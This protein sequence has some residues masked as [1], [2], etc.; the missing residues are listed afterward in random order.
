MSGS[1]HPIKWDDSQLRVINA[2]SKDRVVVGAGPG[3]GKTAV[4]CAR[5]S[6]LIDR[7]SLEP[8]HIWLISFTRTAIREIHARIAAR[9]QNSSA[10]DAVRIA[11]L[12]S[13]AWAIHSGFH[14]EAQILGSYEDNIEKALD[15]IRGEEHV[16]EY[17]E[18]IEHLIIDE[19]QDIVGI[20]SDLLLAII[21][22]LLPTCGVTVF[23]DEAQAIY[24]FADD[25]EVRPGEAR[26]SSLLEKIRLQSDSEFQERELTT[27]HRTSSPQLLQIFSDTRRKV[28]AIANG[29]Q[30]KPVEIKNEVI[31]LAHGEVPQDHDAALAE[32]DPDAFVLYRR[33]CDVLMKSSFLMSKKIPHRVR[34][35]GL[36]TCIMPWIGAS[37]SQHVEPNLDR[38]KFKELWAD[39]VQKT[40]LET[41]DCDSAWESLVSLAGRTNTLVDMR[42]LRQRLGRKQ[43]P[44]EFCHPEMGLHGPIISTIHAA[45]GREANIVHLML[46]PGKS[47]NVDQGEEARVVFVGATRG[48]SQLL[49]GRSPFQHVRKIEDSGR[50]YRL[51]R[52][53]KKLPQVEIGRD[54]D[55][56]AEGLTGRRL[57][58]DVE[59]VHASQAMIRNFASESISL[60]AIS[61]RE[62]DFAYRLRKNE[63]TP[64]LAV[65][66]KGVN[67]DLFDVAKDVQKN[68]GGSP[69]RPP[70][71]INHLHV[72]G[73]RTIVLPPDAPEEEKLHEPW[74][75]SGIMLAPLILGY[76]AMPFPFRRKAPRAYRKWR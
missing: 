45:K 14:D 31:K 28:L 66:S 73:V 50:A 70:N 33:R 8:S 16:A 49:I 41:C 7:D 47:Q 35:S 62:A 64:C 54:G 44:A 61:D 12:D 39:S 24:G 55:I 57:F 68:L 75:S 69:R 15:L 34:M 21:R 76:S 58:P 1:V 36:P 59:L 9:L 52:G 19:A 74:G 30:N 17:L 2:P 32:L 11:T 20:R 3:T 37:L 71:K 72:H 51:P 10:A 13:S 29:P 53:D 6:Q 25:R 27:I 63:Q 56:L 22:K 5:V 38:G 40:S 4:A 48:R 23:A 67:R 42:L 18:R 60:T 46:P 26:E 43:P 65:L